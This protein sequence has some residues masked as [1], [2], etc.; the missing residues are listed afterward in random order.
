MIVATVV[1]L[2]LP[3]T[4]Q[5]QAVDRTQADAVGIVCPKLQPLSGIDEISGVVVMVAC[6][7]SL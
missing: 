6:G 1:F 4:R 7:C 2:L 5:T 3:E